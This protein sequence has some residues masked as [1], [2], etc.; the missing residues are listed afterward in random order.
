M[1]FF[2]KMLIQFLAHI[3]ENQKIYSTPVKIDAVPKLKAPLT[4][5]QL[6]SFLGLTGYFRKFTQNYCIFSKPLTDLTRNNTKF[7]MGPKLETSVCKWKKI[8]TAN[9]VL[10]IYNQKLETELH[11]D[12]SIDGFCAILLQKSLDDGQIHQ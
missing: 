5:K 6:E 10:S 3:I 7:L 8:L 11:T 2:S 4:L 9:P 12:A 1:F